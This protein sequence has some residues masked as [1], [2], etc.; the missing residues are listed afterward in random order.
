M[1]HR[2]AAGEVWAFNLVRY[3]YSGGGFKGVSWSLGG[4][5]A[6]PGKFGHLGFG[7]FA[8]YAESTLQRMVPAL[9]RTMAAI[10]SEINV[11]GPVSNPVPLTTPDAGRVV[12]Y[13]TINYP[14]AEPES[15]AQN[16]ALQYASEPS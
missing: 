10:S 5:Y 13:N 14:V 9:R 8:P 11:T 15:I 1:E 3:G 7:H 4:S 2:P 6:S 16:R 12:Q